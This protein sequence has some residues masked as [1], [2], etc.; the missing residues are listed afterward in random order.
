MT[1]MDPNGESCFL[2]GLTGNIGA[3][4]STVAD[5]LRKAGAAIIEADA[6]GKEVV[7]QSR[8]F[9]NWL[10]Q[11]YG[12]GIFT[13]DRL[14]RAALGRIVFTDPQAKKDLDDH[15]WP[16][17]RDLLTDRI[18]ENA[19]N[20][21]VVVVDAAMIF[22]WGDE[23]RYDHILTIHADPE[24]AVPRAAE[25]LGQPLESIWER[26][27]SQIPIEQ[28]MSRSDTVIHNDGTLMQLQEKVRR[29]WV[30]VVAPRLL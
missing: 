2:I 14:D 9:R 3:G 8:N 13:E 16:Y 7:D 17:I 23:D 6:L 18:V 5:F 20:A 4:K 27:H 19:K 25:R 29:F 30:N 10:R 21:D 15:I 22:E 26:Y 11:R 1:G 12:E 28:K 24:E